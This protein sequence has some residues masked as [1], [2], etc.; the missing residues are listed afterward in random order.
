M[1]ECEGEKDRSFLP[2]E[3]VPRLER[4][5]P[6]HGLDDGGRRETIP[7]AFLPPLK[8]KGGAASVIKQERLKKK[9]KRKGTRRQRK[10]LAELSCEW[11]AR[12]SSSAA[13][14][15]ILGLGRSLS[16]LA[17]VKILLS[18]AA[19]PWGRSGSGVLPV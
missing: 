3:G 1:E 12:C 19:P 8:K 18:L 6:P 13:G 9:R 14:G 10:S 11:G 4:G 16:E 5:L 7:A 17:P 15:R 2:S